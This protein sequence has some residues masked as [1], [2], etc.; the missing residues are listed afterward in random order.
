M[1]PVRNVFAKTYSSSRFHFGKARVRTRS[2][3]ALWLPDRSPW[4]F[5]RRRQAYA[6]PG[7]CGPG[8]RAPRQ[9]GS[10]LRRADY[11]RMGVS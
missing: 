8:Q 1:I 9:L 2:R 5:A 7:S 3:Q 4:L 6:Q 10:R 11:S